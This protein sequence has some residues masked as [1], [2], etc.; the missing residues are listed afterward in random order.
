MAGC[1]VVSSG[2]VEFSKAGKETLGQ[3]WSGGVRS[4]R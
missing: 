4:G 2:A 1:G 3:S